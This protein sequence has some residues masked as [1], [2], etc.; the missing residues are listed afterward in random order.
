MQAAHFSTAVASPAKQSGGTGELFHRSRHRR[1]AHRQQA[2]FRAS[3]P[4]SKGR[5]SRA[6]V[7]G[8]TW[9]PLV[10][11]FRTCC[12]CRRYVRSRGKNGS[13]CWRARGPL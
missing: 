8:D 5:L 13:L 11:T 7:L 10:G 2:L 4:G 12:G 9:C 3:F 6:T 1:H